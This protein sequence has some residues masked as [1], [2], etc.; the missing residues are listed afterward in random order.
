MKDR[1]LRKRL[2]V[3]ERDRRFGGW[4]GGG[5]RS[6]DGA[7]ILPCWSGDD[8]YDFCIYKRDVWP[9][10]APLLVDEDSPALVEEEARL[11]LAFGRDGSNISLGVPLDYDMINIM[12]RPYAKLMAKVIDYNIAGIFYEECC[13]AS[14][15]IIFAY[16]ILDPWTVPDIVASPPSPYVPWATQPR[17]TFTDNLLGGAPTGFLNPATNQVDNYLGYCHA[18]TAEAKITDFSTDPALPLNGSIVFNIHAAS[19]ADV[20]DGHEPI[21]TGMH[22]RAGVFSGWWNFSTLPP[23]PPFID[24]EGI[25][26]IGQKSLIMRLTGVAPSTIYGIGFYAMTLSDMQLIRIATGAFFKVGTPFMTA[27]VPLPYVRRTYLH[28]FTGEGLACGVASKLTTDTTGASSGYESQLLY[29]LEDNDV[30]NSSDV[31][32]WHN[33]SL[34][35]LNPTGQKILAINL[36]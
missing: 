7:H 17:T 8:R 35:G 34:S 33:K 13:L 21:T 6:L 25:D 1:E 20:N 29:Q 14:P 32:C 15:L 16:P 27:A 28:A 10:V 19:E 9:D 31:Y 2:Q 4:R 24:P 3:L 12:C 30:K 26:N 18:C 11:F 22:P 23:S 5:G 36:V